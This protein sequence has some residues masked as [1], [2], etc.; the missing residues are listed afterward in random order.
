MKDSYN[1]L[2]LD[3]PFC[4][5]CNSKC[6]IASW[7]TNNSVSEKEQKNFFEFAL[8]E[9]NNIPESKSPE[10]GKKY[11]DFPAWIRSKINNKSFLEEIKTT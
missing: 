6:D 1:D 7:G 5:Y 3:N 10:L 9:I 4:L 2:D 11:F 8:H